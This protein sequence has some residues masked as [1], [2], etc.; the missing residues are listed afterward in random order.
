MLIRAYSHLHYLNMGHYI[1]ECG[2]TSVK[3]VFAEIILANLDIKTLVKFEELLK[4]RYSTNLM[5]QVF[6]I[7]CWIHPLKY[8]SSSFSAL[9]EF[10]NLNGVANESFCVEFQSSFLYIIEVYS[11]KR[12]MLIEEIR[13]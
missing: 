4:I 1:F 7:I 10:S 12:S 2:N 11:T 3:C 13:C 5:H 6:N 8:F 9:I